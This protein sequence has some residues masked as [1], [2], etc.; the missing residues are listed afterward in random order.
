MDHRIAPG[1]WHHTTRSHFE[2]TKESKTAG[3]AE[4]L[5]LV[6]AWPLSFWDLKESYYFNE[7]TTD[8][9]SDGDETTHFFSPHPTYAKCSVVSVSVAFGPRVR[10]VVEQAAHDLQTR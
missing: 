5:Q 2:A 3:S 1:S 7:R 8:G 10:A 6:K 4:G 9:S